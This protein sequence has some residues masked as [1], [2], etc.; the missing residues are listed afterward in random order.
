[1]GGGFGCYEGLVLGQDGGVVWCRALPS[2]VSRQ[3]WFSRADEGGVAISGVSGVVVGVFKFAPGTTQ[4]FGSLGGVAQVL[5]AVATG[6]SGMLLVSMW[7]FVAGIGLV[8]CGVVVERVCG[9]WCAWAWAMVAPGDGG[10]GA[11][12]GLHVGDF[13]WVPLGLG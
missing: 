6:S 12:A 9:L 2:G 1:M 8:L 5:A 7:S 10:F 4:L 3:L 11:G 13:V